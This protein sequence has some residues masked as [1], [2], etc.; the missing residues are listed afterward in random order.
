MHESEKGEHLTSSLAIVAGRRSPSVP[1]PYGDIVWCQHPKGIFIR[2]II[3]DIDCKWS[4]FD[5]TASGK[6]L[7]RLSLIPVK[8]RAHFK[9]F[10]TAGNGKVVR[11]QF[12]GLSN[13]FE[14]KTGR[15][16][17]HVAV[18]DGNGTAFILDSD[19]GDIPGAVLESADDL[20]QFAGI[21]LEGGVLPDT[22]INLHLEAVITG[23]P[24]SL[25]AY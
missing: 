12:H 10:F 2:L 25:N 5:G 21:R 22:V 14:N 24:Q 23:I 20:L 9:N 3:T 13:S 17:R 4:P 1:Y 7:Y 6:L 18:M 11:E 8:T 16:A 19:A 15:A